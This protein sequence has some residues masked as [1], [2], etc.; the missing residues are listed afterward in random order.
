MKKAT[1]MTCCILVSAL[2]QAA[3]AP[4]YSKRGN[5][6]DSTQLTPVPHARFMN[7]EALKEYKKCLASYKGKSEQCRNMGYE[8]TVP[9]S[10]DSE[11]VAVATKLRKSWQRF[12]DRYYWRSMVRLNNPTMLMSH[13]WLDWSSGGNK[14]QT[15]QFILNVDKGMYPKELAG[16]IPEQQPDP[17]LMLDSYGIAPQVPNRDYCN[18]LSMDLTLMYLPGT[19]VYLGSA[20]LF[21]IEGLKRSMNPLAPAPIAFR[22]D[23]AVR[24]VQQAVKEAHS[25]YLKE[26]AQDVAQ[27]LAPNGKFTPLL[28]TGLGDAV[29]APTM[30]AKP[31]VAFVT[32]RAQE[33]GSRLGGVFQATAY[34]YYLQGL[35]GPSAVLRA[36]LLPTSRDVLGVP[37]PPGVWKLEEFKRRFPVNNPVMYERFGYTNLFQAWNETKPRLLPESAGAKPLRQMIYMATGGNVYLPRLTPVPVPA[38]MLIGPFAPGLPYTGPQTQFTWVSVGE[39]YEVPRVSGNPTGYGAVTK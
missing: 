22:E 6:Y 9:Y 7:V 39:G 8:F 29:V 36:H 21:C 18:G 28:W 4:D 34:P 10:L 1:F 16:K 35:S 23:L 5:I 14:T 11:T 30:S 12:E 19:C 20:K 31:N 17:R 13:C 2:A 38:P 3:D 15:A 26:Y 25:D 24:R 33:A 27:A 32:A 37:N